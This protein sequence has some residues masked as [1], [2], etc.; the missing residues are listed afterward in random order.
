MM[1]INWKRKWVAAAFAVCVAACNTNNAVDKT[2]ATGQPADSSKGVEV[3]TFQTK[4]GFGYSI[5]VNHKEF[6]RQN[7]IPVIQGNKPFAS[8]TQAA[9]TGRLVAQKIRN[10]EIPT[11]TLQELSKLGI[12][13]Q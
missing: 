3:Y 10:K 4:D 1:I 9:Q 13:Q 8:E 12:T 11:L 7:C 5:M 6:I 2:A